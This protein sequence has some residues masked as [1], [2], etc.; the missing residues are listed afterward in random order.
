MRVQRDIPTKA[1]IA[2][3]DRNNLR[4]LLQPELEK[5]NIKCSCIRCR[6]I[7]GKEIKSKVDFEIIEYDASSGK[8]FFISLVNRGSLIGF[9]RLRLP[10]S[11]MIREID[12]DSAVL[13][14]LHI[15]GPAEQ[16][17]RKGDVQHRG[18][19]SRLL[20]KAEEIAKKQGKKRMVVI[21][22]VGAKEYYRKF[23]YK[24]E[25]PYMVRFL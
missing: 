5:Q 14:E 18:F 4:Q 2:G 21:S 7:K 19:G 3:V 17:G 23:G 9:T 20:K 10:S 13:R 22:G 1:T 6:E 16:I 12:K 8:E 15:Y 24:N 25:G 11:Y